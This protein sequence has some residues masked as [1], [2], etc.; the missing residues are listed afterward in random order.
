MKKAEY[1]HVPVVYSFKQIDEDTV[2]VD[3]C[4]CARKTAVTYLDPR[5][6]VHNKN[7]EEYEA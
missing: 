5:G 1:G 7:C 2:K 6:V 4:T 3:Y